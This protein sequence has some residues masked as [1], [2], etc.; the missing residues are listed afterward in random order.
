MPKVQDVRRFQ[1]TG[2][3]VA[4]GLFSQEEVESYREHFMQ[5]RAAGTYPGDF[6][7][8][9]LTSSDPLKTLSPDDP[10]APLGRYQPELD[11]GRAAE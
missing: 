3:V 2:Y 6:A 1:Q 10:H 9:D 4:R 5:M 7:G 11:A 8:V